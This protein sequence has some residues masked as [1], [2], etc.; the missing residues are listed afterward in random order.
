M[1]GSNPAGHVGMPIG[2]SAYSWLGL[3]SQHPLS[4][5]SSSSFASHAALQCSSSYAFSFKACSSSP[6]A[7]WHLDA[8]A[9]GVAHTTP[10]GGE[11]GGVGDGDGG[12]GGRGDGGDDGGDGGG[13]VDGGDGGGAG[14]GDECGA[15]R[16]HSD[17]Q[18]NMR[19]PHCERATVPY[20]HS[21]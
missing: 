12:G 14:G 6:S 11:G 1:S 19:W 21:Q 17:W 5:P 7:G 16:L 9:N 20:V 13:G 4:R 3:R 2:C 10:V 18:V 15:L 8:S